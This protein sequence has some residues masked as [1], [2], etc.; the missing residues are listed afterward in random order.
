MS[1]ADDS[2]QSTNWK[3]CIGWA[4]K[5]FFFLLQIRN[6]HSPEPLPPKYNCCQKVHFHFYTKWLVKLDMKSVSFSYS[7]NRHLASGIS[8]RSLTL[9]VICLWLRE[10]K[11]VSQTFHFESKITLNFRLKHKHA[12]IQ[13]GEWHSKTREK[14]FKYLKMMILCLFFGE[15]SLGYCERNKKIEW[16]LRKTR[17]ETLFPLFL[18]NRERE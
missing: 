15:T 7:L 5:M 4:G 2:S 11:R 8:I 6:F 13:H 10:S 9:A 17:H 12:I 3:F 14:M 16:N 1:E 18:R